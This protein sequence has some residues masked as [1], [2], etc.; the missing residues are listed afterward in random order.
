MKIIN[1][2]TVRKRIKIIVATLCIVTNL[3]VTN[4]LVCYA[5]ALPVPDPESTAEIIDLCKYVA[6]KNGIAVTTGATVAEM[7]GGGLT[8]SMLA[9]YLVGA[10]AIGA[11]GYLGY[12]IYTNWDDIYEDVYTW[13]HGRSA[14]ANYWFEEYGQSILDGTVDL[15]KGVKVPVSIFR[16]MTVCLNEI[17]CFDNTATFESSSTVMYGN[18]NNYLTATEINN[19]VS[20]ITNGEETYTTGDSAHAYNGVILIRNEKNGYEILAKDTTSNYYQPTRNIIFCGEAGGY[21]NIKWWDSSLLNEV[22]YALTNAFD[23]FS[24]VYR[25][26]FESGG[27]SWANKWDLS[28]L[29]IDQKTGKISW[30]NSTSGL[31]W[32]FYFLL[33]ANSTLVFGNYSYSELTY[34]LNVQS[35]YTTNT[36]YWGVLPWYTNVTIF[37]KGKNSLIVSNVQQTTPQLTLDL[38]NTQ[39]NDLILPIK[40]N[41]LAPTL[42]TNPVL[43]DVPIKEYI[44]DT[45]D[46]DTGTDTS[47]GILSGI[48]SLIDKIIE[49]LQ[50]IWEAIL[51]IPSILSDIWDFIQ[52]IP[53][54]IV[55]GIS[56]AL[57]ALFTPSQ[58]TV[59]EMQNI[60]NQKMPF[61]AD[62]YSWVDE[63]MKI[64]QRPDEY[65]STLTF[66]VDMSKAENTYWD[67][68]SSKSNAINASWYLKY[69]NTVDDII[70]GIA[71]LIFLWN[72]HCQLPSIISAV[73]STTFASANLDYQKYSVSSRTKKMNEALSKEKDGD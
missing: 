38:D 54:I 69:K 60:L 8:A 71:W 10:T 3:I 28:G 70:V 11:V 66:M 58:S 34:P 43:A 52:T 16:E 59:D 40:V 23:S 13:F 1:F 12:D 35:P 42:D 7:V 30:T 4:N 24:A 41:D 61:I 21:M 46:T 53:G 14:Y 5:S 29:S 27:Y 15:S 65:A 56:A 63:L 51:S 36:S 73:S 49:L 6:E 55:D 67:Y 62:I 18:N 44:K 31:T 72:V 19:W 64:M 20:Q 22:G 9:P 26:S 47:D 45:S 37:G 39:D 50:K 48:S 33:S 68:G 32:D 2:L 57:E 25:S 17:L